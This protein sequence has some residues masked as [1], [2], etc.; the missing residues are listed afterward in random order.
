MI[1]KALTLLLLSIVLSSAA[2]IE[3]DEKLTAILGIP[4]IPMY[5][6]SSY[7][8]LY[9]NPKSEYGLDPGFY[10]PVFEFSYTK[11]KTTED[12]KFVIPDETTSHRMST[13]SFT[14]EVNSFRGTQSYQEDLKKIAQVSLGSTKLL[15]FSF[16]M[17]RSW[18]RLYNTTSV[19]KMSLTHASAECQAYEIILDKF[20]LPKLSEDF[21]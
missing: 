2:F 13:C 19:Q 9:G 16:S 1:Q 3:T 18:E 4:K 11:N 6:G 7:H 12:E 15:G 17:S 21:V 20:S 14:T 5:V 10:H 8:I